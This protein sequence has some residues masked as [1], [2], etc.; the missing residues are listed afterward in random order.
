MGRG[1]GSQSAAT[2]LAPEGSIPSRSTFG[3]SASA[4]GGGRAM[5][6]SDDDDEDNAPF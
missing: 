1:D 6:L 3:N 2:H 5:K 4:F